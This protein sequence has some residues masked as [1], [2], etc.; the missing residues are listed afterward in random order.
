MATKPVSSQVCIRSSWFPQSLW[1]KEYG[2]SEEVRRWAFC[3]FTV[4][5]WKGPDSMPGTAT[6]PLHTVCY[7]IIELTQDF[8]A[9]SRPCS[10]YSSTWE[11]THGYCFHQ[12]TRQDAT[13]KT[14]STSII[15]REFNM[16]IWLKRYS[17]NAGH[18]RNPWV[19]K[20]ATAESSYH[21]SVGDQREE[22]C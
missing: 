21:S 15:L 13:R 1:S 8:R 16:G 10:P 14:E 6:P 19:A 7:Y 17:M 3:F 12:C 9:T 18:E 4:G 11:R 22:R 5:W 20:R 2:R